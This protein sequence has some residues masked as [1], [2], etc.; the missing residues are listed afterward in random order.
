MAAGTSAQAV[1]SSAGAAQAGPLAASSG[2]QPDNVAAAAAGGGGGRSFLE[3]RAS[4]PAA[5]AL[6]HASPALHLQLLNACGA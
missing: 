5:T 3:G 1:G 2:Q 4:P 6:P